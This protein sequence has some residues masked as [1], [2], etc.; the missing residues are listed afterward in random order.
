MAHGVIHMASSLA[1]LSWKHHL[2]ILSAPLPDLN[3][4]QWPGFTFSCS[5]VAVLTLTFTAQ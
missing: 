3:L 4:V 5:S 1:Q 2:S